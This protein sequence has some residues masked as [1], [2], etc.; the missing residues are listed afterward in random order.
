MVIPYTLMLDYLLEMPAAQAARL[1][2]FSVLG[3]TT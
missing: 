1:E 3:S 2:T